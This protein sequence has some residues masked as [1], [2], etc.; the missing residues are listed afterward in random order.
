[1]HQYLKRILVIYVT[2]KNTRI[3]AILQCN[4]PPQKLYMYLLKFIYRMYVSLSV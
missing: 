4:D 3:L 2:N 1:M